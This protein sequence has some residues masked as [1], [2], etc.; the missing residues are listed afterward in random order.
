MTGGAMLSVY[1]AGRR[2]FCL[3]GL[4]LRLAARA[5]GIILEGLP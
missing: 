4:Q 1:G 5:T 2:R 3:A